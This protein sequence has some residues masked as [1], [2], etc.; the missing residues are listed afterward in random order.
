[1]HHSKLSK[2]LGEGVGN[3]VTHGPGMTNTNVLQLPEGQ[4]HTQQVHEPLTISLPRETPTHPQH[5]EG[6]GG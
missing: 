6:G 5:Q 2:R 3:G 1:M 4:T